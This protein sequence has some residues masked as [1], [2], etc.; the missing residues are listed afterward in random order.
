M[1]KSMAMALPSYAMSVCKLPKKLCQEMSKE[2]ARYW[3]GATKE[4]KKIHWTR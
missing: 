3:W 1:L 4:E 2:M